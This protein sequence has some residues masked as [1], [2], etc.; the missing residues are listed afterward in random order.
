LSAALQWGGYLALRTGRYSLARRALVESVAAA[1]A[2]NNGAVLAWAHL[3]LANLALDVGD[4]VTGTNELRLAH[5]LLAVQGDRWGL[6]TEAG[7]EARLAHSRG[8]AGAARI[9]Y[10]RT[11]DSLRAIGNSYATLEHY[12][13]L[14]Q[15]EQEQRE[16]DASDRWLREADRVARGREAPGWI[17]ERPVN[18]AMNS[19]GRG[20]LKRADSLLT[21]VL[22]RPTGSNRIFRFDLVTQHAEVLARQGDFDAVELRLTQAANA[23]ESWRQEQGDDRE[24]RVA[25]LQARKATGYSGAG[26]PYAIG[27]LARSGRIASAFTFAEER[28]ARDLVARIAERDA[29]ATDDA[30][31]TS[32]R[33]LRAPTSVVSLEETRRALRDSTALV[34]FVT[35]RG[36]ESVTALV[37]T[38]EGADAVSLAP[39]DSLAGIGR[40]L[41]T[42]VAGGTDAT[43]LAQQ[44]GAALLG[45][46]LSRL[47]PKITRLVIVPDGA[48]HRVPFEVV[49]TADGK[50]LIERFA[51]SIAP[52]ATALVRLQQRAVPRASP[53]LLV[54]GDPEYS[55]SRE[56]A[57]GAASSTEGLGSEF[58][59]GFAAAGGLARLPNSAREA[60]SVAGYFASADVRLGANASE[61]ALRSATLRKV[62]VIHFATHALVDDQVVWRSALA[63]APGRGYDGFVGASDVASLDLGAELVVLSGCRTAQGAVLTGEGVQGLTAPFLESGARA[64]LAT[65]WA[66]GDRDAAVM[67]DRFYAAMAAGRS[68][69]DA[70]RQAAREG[71][72]SG[73]RASVW[74]AFTLV[75]DPG[76][77]LAL[78]RR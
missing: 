4:F 41:S 31:E 11:I 15:L 6:A 55:Q 45:P 54:F 59:S 37:I 16:W 69:S 57:R 20:D 1:E 46:V 68:A 39:L 44:L 43:Q 34:E 65:R 40:R 13:A 14:A 73:L 33:Q 10:L 74:G 51:I 58:R 49:R 76:V 72:A 77:T 26:V 63:L 32:R 3:G 23:F 29:P 47:S 70:L 67:V 36:N 5:A 48:L 8:D 75:G 64:V 22:N 78:R 42:L 12:R 7:L 24:F 18:D 17:A 2:S 38:R 28:R 61:S 52:S 66:I 21:S 9:A 53:T 71:I 62:S 50:P 35:G 60:R 56:F 27:A 25:L 19:L 30:R